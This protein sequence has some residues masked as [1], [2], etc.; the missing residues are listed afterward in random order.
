MLVI[1]FIA[2]TLILLLAFLAGKFFVFKSGD[3]NKVS[4]LAVFITFLLFFYCFAIILLILKSAPQG[5]FPLLVCVLSPFI[6]GEYATY[7]K[8]DLYTNLQIFSLSVS[9]ILG[10]SLL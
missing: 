4:N 10:I 7:K 8:L 1:F 9:L 6:L 3:V 5:I 2:V